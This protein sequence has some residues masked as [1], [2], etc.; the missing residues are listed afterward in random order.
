MKFNKQNAK[1]M[2]VLRLDPLR[3]LILAEQKLIIK[4]L[5]R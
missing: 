5:N 4:I 3:E 1:I 2:I